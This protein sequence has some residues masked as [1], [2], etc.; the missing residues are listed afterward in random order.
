M[1]P[2]VNGCARRTEKAGKMENRTGKA[3]LLGTSAFD[4][5]FWDHQVHSDDNFSRE[6]AEGIV[7][8]RCVRERR[9]VDLGV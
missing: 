1:R 3:C 5:Q 4:P 9:K 8:S 6:L 7:T 2:R